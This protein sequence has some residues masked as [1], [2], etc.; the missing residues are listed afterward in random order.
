LEK[1]LR[2]ENTTGIRAFLITGVFKD[3]PFNST[4]QANFIGHIE[5]SAD[6][7]RSRGWR[8]SGTDTYIQ[9][10]KGSKKEDFI[11]KLNDFAQL[12]HPDQDYLYSLQKLTDVYFHSDFI[13][14]NSEPVGNYKLIRI[15]IIIGIIILLIASINYIIITTASS[16]ER[17]TEI[18]IRKVMGAQR[19]TII[20][21]LI[22]ESV[23]VSLIA[24]PLA[25]IISELATPTF[26]LLLGKQLQIN[27]LNNWPYSLGI[28]LI[29]LFISLL[30]GSYIS[31]FVSKFTPEQI[32]KKRFSS[33]NS[34]FNFRKIL[35]A[36]QI[37]AFMILFSF[38]AIII[39]QIN[40]ILNKDIG[41]DYENLVNVIPPHVHSFYGSKSFKDEILKNPSIESVSEVYAGIYSDVF[42]QTE[43]SSSSHPEE[44][45][46]FNFLS[47]DYNYSQI[48][49]FKLI[50]GRFFEENRSSD[51]AAVILNKT[52]VQKMD[53][54]DPLNQVLENQSGQRYR[55]I[56]IIDDFHFS[57][58]HSTIMPMGII[59]P[60]KETMV[61][62][63]LVKINPQ[64]VKETI[65]FLESSWKGY[66]PA[67]KFEY[68]FVKNAIEDKYQDDRNFSNTIQVLTLITVLIAAFGIFGFSFYNARQR[69]KEIGI[70]K[71]Y[72]ANLTDIIKMIY[73][74]LGIL[75][76][77]SGI[78]AIP[79]AYII[80]DKWLSNYA[81]RI[82]FP[83]WIFAIVF[84]ISIIIVFATPG[85]TALNAAN[86]NPVDS[87]RYE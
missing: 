10:K 86:K 84:V 76:V 9:L 73:K 58:M 19:A 4:I 24:F 1:T 56:G 16:T 78:I 14:F 63:I 8:I 11:T 62:Q 69:V 27:Y 81:Y 5:L 57:S 72:G 32:F 52:A 22:T 83:Y 59:L 33:N 6:L 65:A 50:E 42:Y 13:S 61:C 40:F 82:E 64:Q 46:E 68:E 60:K 75:L 85:L 35:I 48:L 3:L 55:V 20:K 25:I 2:V 23:L 34:K 36:I 28:L 44:F 45:V 79:V 66:G 54:D 18:G 37:I 77:L 38:S 21:Q 67:G 87:L 29:T 12:Q 31:L 15:Y 41:F 30:S 39:K 74:E 80:S 70:R 26:N 7:Y 49:D 47:G 51:T 43:L 53:L 17:M 71:V